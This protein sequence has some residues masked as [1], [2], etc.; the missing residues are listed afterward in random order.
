MPEPKFDGEFTMRRTRGG[1]TLAEILIA[2]ALIAI[3]AAV[4]L[5]T[6]AGQIG[7]G[8]SGRTSQDLNAI[9]A[10]VEQFLA[11]VHRYPG[12]YSQLTKKITTSDKDINLTTYPSGL[13]AAWSGPYTTKLLNDANVL[14][15]GFGAVIRDTL[16]KTL[17]ASN[18]INYVTVLIVGIDSA[19]FARLDLDIDGASSS[20]ANA[21]AQGQ[22][23]FAPNAGSD[24]T[25]Y[26]AMPIQ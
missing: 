20:W 11:D 6:V 2:L 14:P 21:I 22:L 1:F 9:R 4:L 10:G 24:T 18:S 3:L 17:N 12:K 8:D 13:V 19:G 15:T 5:P 23:R 25:R 26:L 7:K 16:V